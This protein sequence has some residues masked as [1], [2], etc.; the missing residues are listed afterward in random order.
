MRHE[1]AG[2]DMRFYLD[3]L[4]SNGCLCEGKKQRG[5]SFCWRCYNEL[6]AQMK[7]ALYRRIGDGYEEA[8]EDAVTWLQ[9]NLW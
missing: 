8:Y 4:M 7:R 5:H 1:I 3:S 9:R 6:P 2:K